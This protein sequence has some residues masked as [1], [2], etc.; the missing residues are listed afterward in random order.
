MELTLF[1]GMVKT[2]KAPFF[3]TINKLLSDENICFF[4]SHWLSFFLHFL[5]YYHILSSSFPFL[6]LC[7]Q[8]AQ[9]EEVFHPV[10]SQA[11]LFQKMTFEVQRLLP[12]ICNKCSL[13][14]SF[15]FLLLTATFSKREHSVQNMEN[16]EAFRPFV[17]GVAFTGGTQR[18]SNPPFPII[19]LSPAGSSPGVLCLPWP[20]EPRTGHRSRTEQRGKVTSLQLLVTL[21]N[22]S[23][24]LSDLLVH[25]SPFLAHD[26]PAG[27]HDSQVLLLLSIRSPPNLFRSY[28][29]IAF[30]SFSSSLIFFI[31]LS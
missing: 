29:M 21:P 11:K 30:I 18:C 2:V 9:E 24:D 1:F 28:Y 19:L 15:L 25:M 17:E 13:L 12:F 20:G 7:V 4:F 10:P 6:Y 26:W 3:P 5:A 16:R 31:I 14:R 23:Q 22:E 27:H 8:R